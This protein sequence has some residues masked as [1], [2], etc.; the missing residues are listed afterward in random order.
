M[1]TLTRPITVT[2]ILIIIPG[3]II[4]LTSAVTDTLT[5]GMGVILI[6]GTPIIRTIVLGLHSM[7]AIIM[8]IMMVTIMMVIPEEYTP[9]V[10][11]SGMGMEITWR[12]TSLGVQP[13]D[14]HNS[15]LVMVQELRCLLRGNLLREVYHQEM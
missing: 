14:P 10:R 4:I 13:A 15:N 3:L 11:D 6:M 5:M 1:V 7:G 8:T 2:G 12:R 9:R